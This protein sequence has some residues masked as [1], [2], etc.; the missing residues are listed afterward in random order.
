MARLPSTISLMRRGGTPIAFASAVC[1][2]AIGFKNSSI[3]I[4]PGWGFLNSVVVDDFDVVRI[5]LSPDEANP[6]LLVDP[7]RMLSLP[8]GLQRF[9]PVGRRYLQ[10]CKPPRAIQQAQFAQ[11]AFLNV[12]RQSPATMAGPDGRGLTVPETNDHE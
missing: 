6:P 10:I 2:S 12:R 9:E 5:V 8:I 11:G 4:S 3:R 7:D 1:D